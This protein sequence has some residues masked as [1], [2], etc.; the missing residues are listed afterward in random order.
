MIRRVLVSALLA[1][2]ACGAPPPRTDAPLE[3]S[4]GTGPLPEF[5]LVDVNP[6][7]ASAGQ[8]V[9]PTRYRGKVSGWYFTHTS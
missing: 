7:S 9:G 3:P 4:P 5:T 1:L 6:R 8:P 2:S